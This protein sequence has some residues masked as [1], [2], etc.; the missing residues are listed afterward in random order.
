MHWYFFTAWS[1][2]GH[3]IILPTL[4]KDGVSDVKARL[5]FA[6]EEAGFVVCQARAVT[7]SIGCAHYPADGSTAEELLAE[8]DRRM[9][10]SKE[11]YYKQKREPSKVEVPH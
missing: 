9:Y 6:V 3:T 5:E 1:F 10:E 7:A 8:A 2:L 11:A 4:A